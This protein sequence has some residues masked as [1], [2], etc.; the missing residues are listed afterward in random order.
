MLLVRQQDLRTEHIFQ[1]GSA[2]RLKHHH[3]FVLLI[4]KMN[5]GT[6]ILVPLHFVS[7]P[8]VILKNETPG[9]GPNSKNFPFV[10]DFYFSH[11]LII[12]SLFLSV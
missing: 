12:S 9:Q 5:F 8:K 6:K 10:Q 11:H 1:Q 7:L 3:Y 2:E 4:I